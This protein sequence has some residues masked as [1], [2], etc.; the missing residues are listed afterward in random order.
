MSELI[1]VACDI[2]GRRYRWPDERLGDSATCRDCNTQFE[3]TEY[4]SPEEN[5]DAA[6]LRWFKGVGEVL[7]VLAVVIGLSSLL[8]IRPAN[9]RRSIA[10]G[11][12]SFGPVNAHPA[13]SASPH[14]PLH[15]SPPH[16]LFRSRFEARTQP[17]GQAPGEAPVGTVLSP[18]NQTLPPVNLSPLPTRF[19]KIP[20]NTTPEHQAS[21][22]PVVTEWGF[23]SNSR[24]RKLQ[25][26]GQGLQGLT[27]FQYRFGSGLTDTA[28]HQ[29]SDS[30]V[31]T[32]GFFVRSS[33]VTLYVISNPLGT[34]VVFSDD[35]A[36]IDTPTTLNRVPVRDEPDL[37]LVRHGGELTSNRPIGVLVDAGG[38]ATVTP[39]VNMAIVKPGGYLKT[40]SPSSTILETGASV[41]WEK[42]GINELAGP[43]S[44]PAI[45]FY[46]LPAIH[47]K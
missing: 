32:D 37:F 16:D 46:R 43:D 5:T 34:A 9:Y 1:D 2:C 42:P 24:P 26:K 27:R 44:R 29:V 41:V 38:R 11:S 35:I 23:A 18:A 12:S 20:P 17:H 28:C 21:S 13:G 47:A 4:V 22:P 14:L 3:V 30:L 15:N 25:L 33:K 8:V 10:Q 6:D 31:E 39:W 36:T 7:L 45:Q 19:T 40:Q